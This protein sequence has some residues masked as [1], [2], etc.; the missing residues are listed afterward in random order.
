MADKIAFKKQLDDCRKQILILKPADR[1]PLRIAKFFIEHTAYWDHPSGSLVK[2]PKHAEN[3]TDGENG[4][5]LKL[6]GNS[7]LIEYAIDSSIR[8]LN[9]VLDSFLKDNPICTYNELN[10][11][12]ILIVRGAVANNNGC[13]YNGYYPCYGSNIFFGTQVI[14]IKNFV[15][16]ILATIKIEKIYNLLKL[17]RTVIVSEK[18][19]ADGRFWRSSQV[20]KRPNAK[21]PICSKP[22]YFI[23]MDNGGRVFFDDLGPP[24]P[25]HP[26]TDSR[27]AQIFI[28][29]CDKEDIPMY[30]EDR[31]WCLL[32]KAKIDKVENIIDPESKITRVYIY[33]Y[34]ESLNRNLKITS[35]INKLKNIESPILVRID[36]SDIGVFDVSY[37]YTV[38]GENTVFTE[39]HKFYSAIGCDI[40]VWEKAL[41]GDPE[42][43]NEV[44]WYHAF[45]LKDNSLHNYQS[46]KYWFSQAMSH[47]NII[48]MHNLG[49]MLLKGLGVNVDCELAF[50]YLMKSAL[51][52]TPTAFR[53]IGNMFQN[54]N[55]VCFNVNNSKIMSQLFYAI[56][57]KLI[58]EEIDNNDKQEFKFGGFIYSTYSIDKYF[59]IE[60]VRKISNIE[61]YIP[62]WNLF[63]LATDGL[64]DSLN[65][66]FDWYD[67]VKIPHGLLDTILFDMDSFLKLD[68]DI[69]LTLR[70]ALRLPPRE[71]LNYFKNASDFLVSYLEVSKYTPDWKYTLM[72][73]IEISLSRIEDS[74]AESMES[75][76][77]VNF[78]NKNSI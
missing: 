44:G 33:G 57:R 12:L 34:C 5:E 25:K 6:G 11:R 31:S 77:H 41:N 51:Q 61:D 53:H 43:E 73:N 76:I 10:D 37:L 55:D 71:F 28:P 70:D 60:T 3:I 54:A 22:V 75:V 13:K 52:M 42:A 7:F 45:F 17:K 67:I 50:Q 46:A 8:L 72:K 26:C 78:S 59:H 38:L 63:W 20:D 56:E 48:G 1:V 24:W 36:D 47:G 15:G 65:S 4:W 9:K 68:G 40:D 23:E 58:L 69:R 14:N 29:I 74:N 32:S 39:T 35:R 19:P 2:A 16:I 18:V 62:I 64:D 30:Q 49:V 66:P 21:C 27:I